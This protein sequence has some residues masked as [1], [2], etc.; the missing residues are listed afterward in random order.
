MV[1]A[2]AGARGYWPR[3]SLTR[4]RPWWQRPWWH[5]AG[6]VVVLAVVAVAAASVWFIV[7]PA[8]PAALTLPRTP[9]AA[10]AGP[11]S[12]TWGVAPGSLAGFRVRM[13]AL[14]VGNEVVGR[15][16][17]VTGAFVIVGNWVTSARLRVR[18]PLVRVGDGAQPQFAQ[19]LRTGQYPVATF[20]LTE[21]VTLGRAFT[22]GAVTTRQ[23]TGWLTMNGTA[24]PVTFTVSGRRD[25][26]SLEVAGSIPVE[27]SYWGIRGP[28]GAGILGSLADAG[29][30]EF[31]LVLNRE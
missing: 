12:G 1:Q 17:A 20:R 28:G 21:D 15:T 2:H 14:G 13:S 9:P 4:R 27:F 3:A 22:S 26:R 18:L 29:V 23:V 30:A 31:R 25:G 10:P 7:S 6:A 11:V 5:W 24:C 16:G 8:A 19:S